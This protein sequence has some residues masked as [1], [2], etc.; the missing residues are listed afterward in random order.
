MSERLA[1]LA[2]SHGIEIAY[3][4]EL[5]ERQRIDD[6]AIRA[7]L[8]ALGVDPD[9]GE[10]GTFASAQHKPS[11][12]CAL[13]PAIAAGRSWG[14]ACQLYG[15]RSDR[16]LGIGDF[17]DLA[18]LAAIAAAEGAS[19]VGVNPIHALFLSDPGRYSPYSPSSR[20]FLNPFYI[21]IDRLE[22]GPEAVEALRARE[23]GLFA[24]LDGDLVDYHKAGRLKRALLEAVFAGRIADIRD[25][26]A[27]ERFREAGGDSLAGFALFEAISQRQV[28]GGSHAGWHSWPEDLQDRFS[29]AVT[30]FGEA[31]ADLVL[32]HTWLQFEAEEQLADAQARARGAGMHIGLYLDLAV[33]VAPDGAETWMDPSLTV[34]NARVGSPPDMFNSQGQ[35]WGLAPLSPKALAD[36]DYRPMREAFEALTR[37]AGAVRIDHAMGLARLW[38]IPDGASSAGGGYV[39]YPLGAM[40]DSVAAASQA[41]HCLVVGEDLGTVPAGFR[42]VMEEAQVLSY[43]V[44]YF[45]RHGE[46]AFLPPEAYPHL[47]LAC[48]S[49]HDLATLAG[50]WRGL[51]VKLREEVGTQDAAATQRDLRQ[52]GRDRL[53]LILAL[54]DAKL[55]PAGMEDFSTGEAALPETLPDAL[56]VAL[57]RFIAR[58][59]ALLV[60]VQLDDMLGSERQSNLP[61]TTDQY[62]NWRIRSPTTLENLAADERFR[63]LAT[64]MREERPAAS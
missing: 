3:I 34:G 50:W 18:R 61:G 30:R 29:D 6:T 16:N 58:T 33:G 20:R 52:R 36:R 38:W 56:A 62:P 47:G 59:P 60:T 22:G 31:N 14:V 25:E 26:Q 32:F 37:H 4:S 48:I 17:E 15:L 51:D 13:P 2:E 27:F 5:G 43:R 19:F 55:L 63:R 11:L 7:L 24:G 49:T 9:S 8:T 35:D 23:P 45:E 39:R 57:H 1:R 12:T 46:T 53:A 10:E 41:N 21:A 40:I 42:G 54:V 64:A 28:E 44:L